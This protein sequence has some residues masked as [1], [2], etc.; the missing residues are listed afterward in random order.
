MPTIR[1]NDDGTLWTQA[2]WERELRRRT[3]ANAENWLTAAF[4][5]VGPEGRPRLYRSLAAAF[6]PDVGGDPALMVAL[7]AVRGRFP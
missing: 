7:N 5:A 1:C 4:V 3:I 2:C 6:H